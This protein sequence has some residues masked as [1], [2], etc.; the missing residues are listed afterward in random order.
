MKFWWVNQGQT[1]TQEVGGGYLWAPKTQRNGVALRSYSLML[2]IAVGDIIY[3]HSDGK[4]RAR[5][6]VRESAVSSPQPANLLEVGQDLWLNDGWLVQ[7]DFETSL[8]T[9]VTRESAAEMRPFLLEEY[10]TPISSNGTA[11]QKTY[12]TRISGQLATYLDAHM[13]FDGL[14]DWEL[15]QLLLESAEEYDREILMDDSISETDKSALILARVGQ[16]KYRLRVLNF[17]RACR[18][19]GVSQPNLLVASHIK[20][21]KDSN[22]LER[23]NGAN[24]L[25]LSPHIDKL[26]D[27][28]AISFNKSGKILVSSGLPKD[29]LAR[30]RIDVSANVGKFSQLQNAFLEFHRDMVFSK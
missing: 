6:V 15:D 17:E 9:V 28:G 3:S 5:G 19:T 10:P 23:L 27:S 7:V 1:F 29:V 24:G 16:G 26:F 20:P 25:M 2:E 14:H 30:W 22:H 8:K 12:L 4:L 11:A 21:W 13:L 18:V